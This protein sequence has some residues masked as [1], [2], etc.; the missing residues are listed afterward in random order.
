[1]NSLRNGLKFSN[2]KIVISEYNKLIAP[3]KGK[4]VKKPVKVKKEKQKKEEE[5]YDQIIK[6]YDNKKLVARELKAAKNSKKIKEEHLKRTNGQ[7]ITRFPPEPNGYLHIG[8]CK[9]IRFNFKLS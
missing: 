8:H 1:M 4:Q 5:D 6:K 3:Y 2:L 7:I 9:A